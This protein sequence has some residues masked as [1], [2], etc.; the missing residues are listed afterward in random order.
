MVKWA[1]TEKLWDYL[2]GYKFTMY[3]D[4]NPLANVRESMLVVAQIDSLANLHCVI[5]H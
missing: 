3:M 1:M 2:L 5:L 4:N